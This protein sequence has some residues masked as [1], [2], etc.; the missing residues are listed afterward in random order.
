MPH[1]LWL[2]QSSG[3]PALEK[4]FSK[5]ACPKHPPKPIVK[6]WSKPRYGQTRTR[7]LGFKGL[8]S[9]LT[10]KLVGTTRHGFTL[11]PPARRGLTILSFHLYRPREVLRT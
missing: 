8:R 5:I 6:K 3:S 10:A 1:M 9:H 2:E 7:V 11:P 4:I